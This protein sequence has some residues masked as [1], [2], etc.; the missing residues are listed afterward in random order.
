MDE[1][2]FINNKYI[3]TD[4]YDINNEKK[5]YL[6]EQADFRKFIEQKNI[7]LGT[8]N[9][10][11]TS[12]NINTV[13]ENSENIIDLI[14]TDDTF[15][16]SSLLSKNMASQ[17]DL[18]RTNS[19]R[20]G[21][22]TVQ[23]G[24][25]LLALRIQ[26]QQAKPTNRFVQEI[27]T[28]VSID[29]K[30]RD[31]TLYPD[32]NSYK[33]DLGKKVFSNVSSVK[34]KS[35]EF[36]NTQQLI[37][38][39]P[40]SQRNNLIYW[41]IEEDRTGGG[42]EQVIYDVSLTPG[43]YNETTLA[44]EIETQMNSVLRIT[45]KPN[46][47]NVTIDSLTDD[48]T[49][50]S[51]EFTTVSNPFSFSIPAVT[52]TVTEILTAL[53]SHGVTIGDRVFIEDSLSADGIDAS[54]FNNGVGHIVTDVTDDDNFTFEILT[55]AT[56]N[57]SGVG[58]S[59]VKIGTGVEFQLLWSQENTPALI[60]GFD[61]E[62]TG[63]GFEI[64]NTKEVFIDWDGDGITDT[65]RLK[66]NK[67]EAA[68]STD[69]SLIRTT[70]PH[71]FTSGDRIFIFT[72]TTLTSGSTIEPYDH[73]YGLS[74]GS[75]TTEENN[76]RL[77]Y[78]AKLADPAGL[79][80]TVVDSNSFTIPIASISIALIDGLIDAVD[81]L[82]EQG[83]IVIKIINAAINLTGDRYFYM[84]SPQ[85]GNMLTTSDVDNIFAKIQLAGSANSLLFNSY[86]GSGKV[87]YD[88]PLSFIDEIEISFR[89]PTNDLFEF[90]DKDHS[91][92]LEIVESIQKMEGIGF[93][94]RIGA[95][96]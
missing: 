43:N 14:N 82:D 33:I 7:D 25:N 80:V 68:D 46:N 48:V 1:T 21:T 83:D 55:I 77:T 62:D 38:E 89:T 19:I 53:T 57:E 13:L 17:Q 12:S 32:Q 71:Q 18:L 65:T 81:D 75:L 20:Y 79:Y 50:T 15:M 66:I 39:T 61:E 69:K 6:K 5:K 67:I 3:N 28:N 41:E 59:S 87:Y 4:V 84:C 95:R 35:T 26:E 40:V 42:I 54:I 90:N 11:T 93:S 47:F 2:N 74:E 8:V 51:I 88:V 58:G 37:K 76:T 31:L 52:G 27:R 85:L 96:T 60:L 24:D 29:S 36:I 22:D 30:D 94:E 64:K 78:I 16:D 92:T 34:L 86:I 73:L 45:G 70:L 9:H 63:F 10:N 72:D 49:F 23:G 56:S 44:A 91:F